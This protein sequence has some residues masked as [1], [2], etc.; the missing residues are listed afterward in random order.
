MSVYSI[1]FIKFESVQPQDKTLLSLRN[2]LLVTQYKKFV[3]K[4]T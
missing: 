1:L 2:C 3:L 4:K